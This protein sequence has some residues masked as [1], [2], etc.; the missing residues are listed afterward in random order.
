MSVHKVHV[1]RGAVL[2]GE[3]PAE[4]YPRG[5][6]RI[7]QDVNPLPGIGTGELSEINDALHQR[8]LQ[9]RLIRSH[10]INIFAVGADR[11]VALCGEERYGTG[12]TAVPLTPA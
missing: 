10:D 8:A 11:N 1:N 3:T 6:E 12:F 9:E 2:A 4:P 5:V 7:R